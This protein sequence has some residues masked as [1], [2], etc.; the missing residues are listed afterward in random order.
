MSSLQHNIA[1]SFREMNFRSRDK[2]PVYFPANRA[3]TLPYPYLAACGRIAG[4]CSEPAYLLTNL[5]FLAAAQNP[6]P[7]SKPA[8]IPYRYVHCSRQIGR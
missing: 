5:K 3:K 8:Q 7:I 6:A 2:L 1:I 4:L